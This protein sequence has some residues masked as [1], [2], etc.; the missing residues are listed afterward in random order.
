VLSTESTDFG[1]GKVPKTTTPEKP[2]PLD[3][4]YQFWAK[5]RSS[6][7]MDRLLRAAS[8]T[9]GKAISSFAGGDKSYSGLAKR[10][11]IDAFKTYDPKRGA[12]LNTHLF[13]RLKPLQREYT[14]RSSIFDVPERVQLERFRL[15]QAEQS[16]NDELGREP[17]DD[18]LSDYLG[19]SKR[20]IAHVRSRSR[21]QFAEGQ[22]RTPEGEP[23]QPTTEV[24][25]PEDIWAEYV[26]HDLDPIDKKILEWKTGMY[27]KKVLSTNEIA[28]RLR[29][30]P[31]AV[32]QRAAK[33][34]MK[35]ENPIGG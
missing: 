25:S 3:E 29:I 16:L 33:I 7:N 23:T 15:E 31:S 4:A 6:E 26:H 8:P 32:S 17:S 5:N 14:Q 21:R 30:T 9:I 1:F 19:L 10:L 22:M 27:G 11:A 24:S 13:I 12:K 20:R 35:L 2:Q 34:A 18:E 28:R